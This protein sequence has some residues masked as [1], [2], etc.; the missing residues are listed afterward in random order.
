VVPDPSFQPLGPVARE[1]RIGDV[2]LGGR[3][4]L[5]PMAGYTDRPFRRLA[6][7]FGAALVVTEMVSARALLEERRKSLEM[8]AFGEDERPIAVQLFGGDPGVMGEAAAI[9][10]KAVAP[11]FL[12]VNFGCPVEKVLRSDSGAALLKDPARAGKIVRAMVEATAGRVPVMVKTRAGFE[13]FDGSALEV[14]RASE[15][16]GAAAFTLHARTR[17]QMYGGTARWEAIAD[18]KRSARIPVIGNGDV[19]TPTDAGR[20]LRE[21][22][23]DAVMVGRGAYGAPWVF[24]GMN[25]YLETGRVPDPLPLKIRLQTA[26]EHF[27][28]ALALLGPKRGLLE[29]RKHLT[30]YVK[31]FDGARDLRQALLVT[32]DPVRVERTL[33]ETIARWGE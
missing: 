19:K 2:R 33:G 8:M 10:L 6:R 1:C 13:S 5:A 18:L 29:M 7:R 4:F 30:H 22:G 9:T 21:T 28:D 16:A 17:K 32:A 12:D 26:L 14:L 3:V 31:G 25:E 27:R 20:M 24:A 15:E 11:D 23:C